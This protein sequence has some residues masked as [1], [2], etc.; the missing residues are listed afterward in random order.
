MYGKSIL[1][2]LLE[3]QVEEMQRRIDDQFLKNLVLGQPMIADIKTSDTMAGTMAHNALINAPI[4]TFVS[5]DEAVEYERNRKKA[6]K[7]FK[8]LG[9]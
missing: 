2:S 5:F 9:D 7:I 4:G 1:N 6:L 8:E 3:R